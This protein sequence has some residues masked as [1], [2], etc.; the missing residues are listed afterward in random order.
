[1]RGMGD[2][3]NRTVPTERS[4]RIRI[5]CR[6]EKRTDSTIHAGRGFS[7]SMRRATVALEKSIVEEPRNSSQ[8]DWGFPMVR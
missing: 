5:R 3:F 2:D 6:G 8:M 1:M 4:T 7:Q